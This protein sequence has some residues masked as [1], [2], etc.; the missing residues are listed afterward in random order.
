MPSGS[1]LKYFRESGGEAHG[2]N[3]HWPG[4]VD[5]FPFRGDKAPTLR[6][7]EVEQLPLALDYHSRSFKLWEPEDR[8]AFD[9][10][11]DR[12]VN[13]WYM[14]HKRFDNFIESQQEYIVRLEWVQVYGEYPQ[15]KHPGS[16]SDAD[17]STVQLAGPA[18]QGRPAGRDRVPPTNDQLI[19]AGARMGTPGHPY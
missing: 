14:Q 5:G 1:M 16:G 4:T 15:S 2:G 3:L 7:S 19:A 10:V 12:V 8:K 6:Q 17:T 9:L 11:M 18:T 13:G